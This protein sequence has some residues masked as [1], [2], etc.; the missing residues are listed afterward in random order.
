[1]RRDAA[2]GA[3]RTGPASVAAARRTSATRAPD[4]GIDARLL[5][6]A[7]A[8]GVLALSSL[9]LLRT[10]ARLRREAGVS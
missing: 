6:A 9:L 3:R 4:Q 8:L 1:M 2:A 7:V 5:A 10:V